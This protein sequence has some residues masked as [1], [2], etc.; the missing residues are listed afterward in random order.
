MSNKLFRVVQTILTLLAVALFSVPAALSAF[1]PVNDDTDIFLANPNIAAERPNVLIILDNTANWNNAFTNEKNALV[2]VING[3]SDQFNVGL[4]MMAETGG[5][6]DN[7]DGGYI[8]Y[9]VR[10]MTNTN[11]TA[12]SSLVNNLDK[13]GDKGNNNTVGLALHEAYLY[14]SGKASISTYGK[15]KAD[16]DGTTDPLLSPLAG[17]HALPKS[18][19]NTSL[20]RSPLSDGCQKNFIIYI[21]NGSANENA[22]ARAFVQGKL[23]TLTGISP[24]TTISITPNGQQGNWGDEMAKYMA[25][26]DVN[27][28]VSGVQNVFTYTL[29]V[30]PVTTG[31]GPDMTA[32]MRSMATQGKGKYF[33][34]SSSAS[35]TAIV[36]ALNTIFT[37]VQSVNSVF[38]STTLPVS[39]NVRGTN[40][41]Q[42]YIG[43]FRPDAVKAPRWLGNLKMYNLALDSN[44]VVYLADA[45]NGIPPAVGNPAVNPSAGRI[46]GSATSFWT[47]PSS[48]WGFRTAEENGVGG[49]SDS[50]DGDLVEKGGVAEQIRIAYATAQ[51]SSPARNLY[52]CSTGG[53]YAD[54]VSNSKLSGT[55]FD[56]SNTALTS[57]TFALGTRNVSPLTGYQ[58]KA[59]TTLTDRKSVT[60]TNAANAVNVSS[61]SNGA[62]TVAIST[63]KT[64][65]PKTVSLLSASVSNPLSV[66]VSSVAKVS[67]NFVVNAAAALP[68][69]FTNGAFVTLSGNSVNAYNGTFTVSNVNTSARTFEI[70]AS[71]NP[72]T[73]SGG[74]ATVTNTINSTTA[75]ATVTAHGFTSGQSITIAGATPAQFNGTF[76]ITKIDND[77]FTYNL[78]S[79]SG[80]ATGTITASGNTT[81][82]TAITAAAHGLAVGNTVNIFG[83][84]PSGYN[85]AFTVATVPNTTT[86]TYTVA[87]AL[88]DA[89]GTLQMTRGGSTTVTVTTA[90][91]HGFSNGNTISIANSNVSGYNGSFTIGGVTSNTFTYTTSSVLPTNTSNTVTASAS[92][93]S[94]VTATTA[95]AHGFSAG[96]TV[97]IEGGTQ[98]LHSGTFTVLATPA[99]TAT[100]FAYTNSQ[101]V[102]PAGSYT[103]RPSTASTKAT[104]TVTAHGYS[105]GQQ[106]VIAGAT[107]AA[108]NGTYTITVVDANTFTF[109]MTT[110]PGPNTGTSVFAKATSTT[111]T[112]N[113][114]GHGF[115]TGD[116]ITVTGATPSA[117]NGTYTVAV[118]DANTFTYTLG[119]AQGDASG[120]IVAAGAS[121]SAT[122]TA[123]INW[124]RGEDN[125]EDE[126]ANS[127]TTDIRASIHGDVLHSKPAV[128]NYNRYGS[129]NDVYVYYGANDAIIRA[130][131]GGYATDARAAVQ[132]Q[133]GMEAW[134]FI[135]VEFMSSLNRLRTNSPS[136]SSSF[137]KPY[138]ADGSISV[139]TKD[140]NG[141]GKLG[142]SGDSVNLYVAMRRGGRLIYALDVNNPHEPRFLWKIDNTSSGFSEL[143]QTWSTPTVVTKLAGYPDPVLVFGGGYDP[144]VE[145][146]NPASI[147]AS[148]AASV[149]TATGTTNRT[150]GRAIYVVNALTGAL[151]WRAVGSGTAASDTTIVSGMDYAIPSD[152]FVAKNETTNV[153]D[154][155]YVGDTG[156]NVWRID[157]R[158]TAGAGFSNTIVTKLASVGGSGAV[159]RKFK[160]PPSVVG[161]TSG[162][163]AVLIGSG[164]REHPFDTSATNRF[165]M[166]KDKGDDT[167]PLTGTSV[168]NPTISEDTMFDATNNC[169]QDPTAC[170]GT[171]VQTNSTV[172]QAAL[173]SATGWFITLGTGEKVV[174]NAVSIA[175]TTFF[176]TNQ[177]SSGAGGGSCGAN[178]GI[179]AQYQV[180]LVDGSVPNPISNLYYAATNRRTEVPGGGYLPPPVPVVVQLGGNPVQAIISGVQVTPATGIKLLSRFKR[181][182]YK[183][184]D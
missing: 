25:N 181:Y 59:I 40:L 171:G 78:A 170:T 79:A 111:A 50:P 64:S 135:P 124:V 88:S 184:I 69:N 82:A 48:F 44:N 29:E 55:P 123:L 148:S 30:D 145:D 163:D 113:S 105:T 11:K 15:V 60:L 112:A 26:N 36:T 8:R 72:G 96:D 103:L 143:G 85:G 42:V 158:Y 146:I 122:R 51:A 140:A 65:T 34:V 20:F 175:G 132:I 137:K 164:D 89:T 77:T 67:S 182:W 119:S 110:A 31:Q 22:T 75:R 165:Y 6:N 169:L 39:V 129:D 43:V 23:E 107:P 63:L 12:L 45:S 168:T 126:N 128:I 151:L 16:N 160:Y 73:G 86:F 114:V 144:A 159:K 139:Y 57:A 1:D 183:E 115:T 120:T 166:F 172:A 134:G 83:A 178:L 90:T 118:T 66:S 87:S 81:T 84:T 121:S 131:K 3:L 28:N 17:N 152:I 179:A 173:V 7:V 13:L 125:F 54:C 95:T 9:H 52:T 162:Y 161:T 61:L 101:T 38:A 53:N 37:E 93:S 155:A 154:R 109:P 108:Y 4:M 153:P 149:T 167:A 47:T 41:N 92:F 150:M 2:S 62:T 32:L 35:G 46:A 68:V 18:P 14:F 100:T 177:P 19:T 127:S 133:P 10:Q 104:A 130:V 157:F 142:D 176:N 70:N 136:I 76:G 80:D 97:I 117:F 180:S 141:N 106:I 174:G 5:S 58:S 147:T 71:G 91:A 27:T 74:T 24:P 156:G 33:A 102:A 98:P 116:S 99:P 49:A 56:T 94:T 138:F 21:S